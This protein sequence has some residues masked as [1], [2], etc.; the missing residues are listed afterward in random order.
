VTALKELRSTR[1]R[2][3]DRKD[4]RRSNYTTNCA[5]LIV[6]S[7]TSATTITVP[8][9]VRE[10]LSKYKTRGKSYGD[11][12][13]EFIEEYPTQEFLDEMDRRFREEPRISLSE[14]RKRS[15]Y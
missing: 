5:E 1:R 8:V 7:D 10:A 11:V 4:V 14:L 13:L 15:A 6:T 12:I 2:P 3:V 9:F